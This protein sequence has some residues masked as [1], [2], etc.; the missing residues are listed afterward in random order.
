[1][2]KRKREEQK[3]EREIA[4]SVGANSTTE[5]A[6]RYP[7]AVTEEEARER[8]RRRR[9]VDREGKGQARKEGRA[10]E[11]RERE[12][13][14]VVYPRT[15]LQTAETLTTTVLTCQLAPLSTYQPSLPT[16]VAACVRVYVSLCVRIYIY[17]CVLNK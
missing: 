1:M 12:R 6:L 2:R 13:K 17:T 10:E 9:R 7:S 3:E 15:S 8:L 14:Y 5:S 4:R 16:V 11:E